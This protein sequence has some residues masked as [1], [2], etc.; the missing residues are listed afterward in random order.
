MAK[1][2]KKRRDVNED[3]E[4]KEEKQ[5]KEKPKKTESDLERMLRQVEE[6][7]GIDPSKLKV[8]RVNTPPRNFKSFIIDFF[9][10]IILNLILV[11]GITGYIEW[12]LYDNIID[13][14]WFTIAFSIIEIGLKYVL[15][16]FF[17][18]LVIRTFGFIFSL[19]TLIAIPLVL[20]LTDFVDVI[21][22]N[23]LLLMFVFML[24]VRSMIRS[25]FA[26]QKLKKHLYRKR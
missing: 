20:L 13:L 9:I 2:D 22:V 6:E 3:V 25:F 7:L 11:L 4:I 8:V 10:T 19:A 12:A 5:K 18:K 23:R 14:A 16:R 21:S 1:N 17:N 15:N 24:I 26:R